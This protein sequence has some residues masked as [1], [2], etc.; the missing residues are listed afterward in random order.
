MANAIQM[1]IDFAGS[2]SKLGK[3]LGVSPQAVNH[4][5]RK[6]TFPPWASIKLEE[7]FP[8]KISRYDLDPEHFGHGT[9]SIIIV[10]ENLGVTSK[11]I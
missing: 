5:H 8:G 1:A 10:L 3:I 9:R 11:T 6:G 7:A 2:Q 4:W